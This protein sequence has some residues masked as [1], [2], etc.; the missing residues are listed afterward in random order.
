MFED[1]DI[2]L[3]TGK[4]KM[5]DSKNEEQLWLQKKTG[6]NLNCS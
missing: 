2:F 3:L 5:I 1:S 4:S 6:L